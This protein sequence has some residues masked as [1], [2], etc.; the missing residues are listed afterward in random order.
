M[1]KFLAVVVCEAC[2]ELQMATSSDLGGTTICQICPA[3]DP[4]P[5]GTKHKG[6]TRQPCCGQPMAILWKST[7]PIPLEWTT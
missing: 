5:K 6:N 3:T 4:C 7:E 1:P 2:N